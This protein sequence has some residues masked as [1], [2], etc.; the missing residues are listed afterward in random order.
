MMATAKSGQQSNDNASVEKTSMFRRMVQKLKKGSTEDDLEVETKI[1]PTERVSTEPSLR[2]A[3]ECTGALSED[4]QDPQ[5]AGKTSMFRR[6]VI[7]LKKESAEDDLDDASKPS[8]RGSSEPSL[9]EV[10][11]YSDSL[12]DELQDLQSLFRTK[13]H[14][15]SIFVRRLQEQTEDNHTLENEILR[16]IRKLEENTQHRISQKDEFIQQLQAHV[17]VLES[18]KEAERT[19]ADAKIRELEKRLVDQAANTRQRVSLKDEEIE[20]LKSRVEVLESE[21]KGFGEARLHV[22]T[23]TLEQGNDVLIDPRP[24]L[25]D[26]QK[27]RKE[28]EQKAARQQEL[29]RKMRE[30]MEASKGLIKT[31]KQDLT[32]K[33]GAHDHGKVK[34]DMTGTSAKKEHAA[35]EMPTLL[36]NGLLLALPDDEQHKPADKKESV[37]F[38]M[39]TLLLNGLPLALPDDE[40]HKP[41]DKKES[42]AFEMPTLLLNGLPLALPDDEQHKPTDKKEAVVFEV[43]T[44]LLNGLPLALPDDEQ[45]KPTDKKEAVVF[46]VPTLLLNGLPLALPD[47]EQ[48]KPTDKKEAVVFEVPTLLLNGLPL[49]LPDDEQHKPTDKKEAVVF[50]VPTLLLNGLPLALP[51]DEQHKPTDKKEAVVFE[52]PTLLLN[53]LPLALPDDEQHKPTDKKEAVVFEVPTLL[54]NGLPLALPDDEQHKPTDKKEAVVF[55]VPTLL[56]NGLP[57][58]LPDDE[59]HKPTDK[60]EAVVFEVPTLLLNGLPLPD[61]EQQ[62]PAD[63]KEHA[64]FEVPTL[65]LNGVPLP[66]DIQHVQTEKEPATAAMPET[67]KPD[68]YPPTNGANE[69]ETFGKET[70]TP[71]GF[72]NRSLPSG[73]ANITEP[74]GNP[75]LELP[76]L[77]ESLA[78]QSVT[79][80]EHRV[81]PE[82]S[83]VHSC[84]LVELDEAIPDSVVQQYLLSKRIAAYAQQTRLM[85]AKDCGLRNVPPENSYPAR[86]SASTPAQACSGDSKLNHSETSAGVVTE[87]LA[88]DITLQ[89]D[90][91]HVQTEKEPATAAMPE[92]D[93]PVKHNEDISQCIPDGYPPTN[94]AN[95]G[96]TFGKEP[97][98]PRGFLNHSLPSGDANITEPSG[99]P[100][101]ELPCPP[102]SL[103]EQSVT[104]SLVEHR[105]HPQSSMVHVCPIGALYEAIP[106]SLVQQYLLSRRLAAY[107]H[108]ARLMVL[109]DSV[110][111]QYL[112]S[113][114]IAAYAQQV[115]LMR[116]MDRGQTNAPPDNP[117]S[118]RKS[119]SSPAKACSG[120]YKLNHSELSQ[121]PSVRLRASSDSLPTPEVGGG[122]IKP[123]FWSAPGVVRNDEPRGLEIVLENSSTPEH[124]H[125]AQQKVLQ[126]C[127]PT[128]SF[129]TSSTNKTATASCQGKSPTLPG[130]EGEDT[131]RN[132]PASFPLALLQSRIQRGHRLTTTLF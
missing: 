64:A 17:A 129:G 7:K 47:D 36:L 106:D 73:D 59:Q 57:L 91:Q 52:V 60:K 120:D 54:L 24:I 21:K 63:K 131:V 71:Q 126:R 114:R 96:E 98:T 78:E 23:Q 116:A 121:R 18:E 25:Q 109:P 53:G 5:K 20:Q 72:L 48:H 35:F 111:K 49:A 101:L 89:D 124:A 95:E 9:K 66:D 3:K 108:Q 2:E 14:Y 1:N 90:R 45:H 39:P 103:A 115:R 11:E 27:M 26:I 117:D 118:V 105:V 99:N 28:N 19:E 41:T 34:K 94:G 93:K 79:L 12:L 42:V 86:K 110:M 43:P 81:H 4:L 8:Q 132:D 122:D 123:Q 67:E 82:S 15:T 127:Q 65:L 56:L 51:D 92:T 87:L 37:A 107:A 22:G 75:E 80:V 50:E 125:A 61:D 76:C 40:Q 104:Q 29:I 62:M 102:E 85:Y 33:I 83:M 6:M 113:Q 58:A 74:S 68:G 55:E 30:Q 70:A 13:Q 77:P 128:D 97:A 16:M 38:E 84:P 119:A 88:N 31:L 112:L 100:D 44:L 46:E 32:E 69:G 10:I 130:T